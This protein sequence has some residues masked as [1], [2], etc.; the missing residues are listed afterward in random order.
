LKIALDEEF[1]FIE[2]DQQ[3]GFCDHG[4]GK[5]DSCRPLEVVRLRPVVPSSGLLR[6][7][8]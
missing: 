7:L 4:L 3:E 5:G 8:G 6:R 2:V 1:G